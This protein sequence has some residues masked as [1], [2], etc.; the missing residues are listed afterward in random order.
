MKI[1]LSA[2]SMAHYRLLKNWK[3]KYEE[4]L[5]GEFGFEYMI[6][7]GSICWENI[8]LYEKVRVQIALLHARGIARGFA[9]AQEKR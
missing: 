8:E 2:T 3:R 5:R 9:F 4:S 6:E 1:R 7:R